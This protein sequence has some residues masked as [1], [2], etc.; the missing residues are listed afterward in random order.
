MMLNPDNLPWIHFQIEDMYM[1]KYLV[2][3]IIV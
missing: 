2:V 3:I 1:Y